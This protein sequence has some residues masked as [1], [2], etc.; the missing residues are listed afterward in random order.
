MI[1]S[2]M[3][4]KGGVGKTSTAI[5]LAAGLGKAGKHVLIV[6]ADGQGTAST[7]LLPDFGFGAQTPET[8]RTLCGLLRGRRTAPQCIWHTGFPHV[9]LIPCDLDLFNTIYELQSNSVNGLPQL[10]LKQILRNLD[11]DEIIIDNNPSINIMSV[12][13]IYAADQLIIPTC[14]DVGGVK[15]VQMTLEHAASVIRELD[16]NA[17]LDYMIL[18]NLVNRNKKE[19]EIAEQLQ[20]IYQGHVYKQQIR[21]Q[22]AP[23]R[24]ANFNYKTVLDNPKAHVALDYRHFVNEVMRTERKDEGAIL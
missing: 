5:Q 18:F 3:N 10:K 11:Y 17:D 21:Y 15:G 8:D 4:V 16:S 14:L 2:I 22:A 7:L 13:S 20:S 23:F 9:D 1:R 24:N 6:D 19:K 12:N